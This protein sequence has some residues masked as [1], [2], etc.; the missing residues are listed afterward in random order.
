MK[1][2]RRH[3]LRA[4]GILVLGLFTISNLKASSLISRVTEI[5]N[6]F[7]ERIIAIIND[8]RKE[9]SNLVEKIM[10]GK[11]YEFNPSTHYPYDGGIKDANT[12][13]QMFFHIHRENEY[14]HFHTFATDKNGNLVHLV[15]ISMNENGESIGLATVN[16]WVTGDNNVKADVLKDLTNKFF[17]EPTLFKDKRIVEFVNY[18]FKAY[19]EE[20]FQLFDERDKW[21]KNYVNNKFN[22][23]FEDREFEILSFMKVDLYD[24]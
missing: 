21:I 16:R 3:F 20:I 22:E 15:L 1:I 5:S 23:P 19:K 6:T 2:K 7:K 8:L 13:Y 18:I 4:G 24:K 11:K 9:G 14:G 12:G 17:V 10:N